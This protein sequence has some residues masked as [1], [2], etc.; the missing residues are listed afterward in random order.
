MGSPKKIRRKYEKPMHPWQRERIE[1][2][3]PLVRKYGLKNKKE[4]W[5]IK[6]VLRGFTSQAKSLEGTAT[7]Q[8]KKES[9]QLLKKL[10]RL[11]LI[12]ANAQ[13][14]DVLS[15]KAED[16]FNRRL[17]TIVY[18]KGLAR[19]SKQARQFIIH[20]HVG[21]NEQKLDVPG[22]LVPL[23]EEPKIGFIANSS[24]VDP[25]HPERK[26]DEVKEVVMTGE[27]D[28]EKK[29]K[30]KRIKKAEK[31]SKEGKKEKVKEDGQKTDKK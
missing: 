31:A 27:T 4:I 28:Q 12:K 25:E 3:K 1:E 26:M 5:K 7:E 15:L 16:I 24:L 8:A 22:Y 6:S 18:S 19:S 30:E 11:G 10:V 17:Q 2:E 9:E 23:D 14:G 29:L 21:I 13:L 20:G